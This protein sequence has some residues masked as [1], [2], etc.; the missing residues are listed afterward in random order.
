M[1]GIMD[2]ASHEAELYPNPLPS[3]KTNAMTDRKSTGL[4][5]EAGAKSSTA[6][7]G[8]GLS[9]NL[10]NP[11][12]VAWMEAHGAELV[13]GIDETTRLQIRGILVQATDEGW[14]Y[15]QTAN[16]ISSRFVEFGVPT[17]GFKNIRNRAELVAVTE[18]HIAY[19]EGN[20]Q[21][22]QSIAEMGVQMD[23]QWVTT[24][25]R[26]RNCEDCVLNEEQGWI[27]L[28]EEYQSGH[29]HTP[30]HAACSC[31]DEKQVK[32]LDDG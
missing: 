28:N 16:A 2:K 3:I 8:F 10:K 18:A 20:F 7:V 23:K 30:A 19:A 15:Q 12:A 5:L 1:G 4:L 21:A 6:E 14:S 31:F 17:P 25:D 26:S 32:G 24:H 29:L 11:R 9:W 27:D 22:A 13:Q